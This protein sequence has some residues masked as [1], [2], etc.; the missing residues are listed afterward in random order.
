MVLLCYGGAETENTLFRRNS[1]ATKLLAAYTK[2]IG[3]R[4]VKETLTPTL[5]RLIA[6]TPTL[7]VL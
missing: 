4:Y 5:Q 6:N 3:G 7:E 2:L 1:M